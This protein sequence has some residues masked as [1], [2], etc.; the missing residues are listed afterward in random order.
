V[1]LASAQLQAVTT[2]RFNSELW[3]E[4]FEQ[5]HK[6]SDWMEEYK[7]AMSGNSSKYFENKDAVLDYKRQLFIPDNLELKTDLSK[8]NTTPSS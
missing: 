8:W 6:D 7:T 4:V 5:G 2:V 3:L 1:V